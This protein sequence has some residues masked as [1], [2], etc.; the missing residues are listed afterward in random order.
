MAILTKIKNKAGLAVGLV[1]FALVAF[2]V[3][4]AI[5]NN[6]GIFRS[7]DMNAGEVN[8]KKISFVELEQ[9]TKEMEGE[10]MLQR[11]LETIDPQT[12]EMI[13]EQVWNTFVEEQTTSVEYEKTGIGH[14]SNEELMDMISGQIQI[15][16][17]NKLLKDKDG[18][19]DRNILNYFLKT[20]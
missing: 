2:V 9:K 12:R 6:I 1:G 13:K 5:N 18:K 8:G 11:N 19:F 3:S 4:D 14:M 10:M 20:N 15:K 16:I 17:F 7:Q